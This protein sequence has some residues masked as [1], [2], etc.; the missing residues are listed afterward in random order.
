VG[1]AGKGAGS[2]L[3]QSLGLVLI[4]ARVKNKKRKITKRKKDNPVAFFRGCLTVFAEL[5][6]IAGFLLALYIF[7][8]GM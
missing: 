4:M 5:A 2:G 1:G 7:L 3:Y 6:G 8:K